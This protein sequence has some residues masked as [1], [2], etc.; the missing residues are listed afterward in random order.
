MEFK[1]NRLVESLANL[2][3][4]SMPMLLRGIINLV[5]QENGGWVIVDYK[6]DQLP[7]IELN[8]AAVHSPRPLSTP[9]VMENLFEDDAHAPL[10]ACAA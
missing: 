8:A 10:N 6:S 4:G 2:A 7:L 9:D 3:S 1:R 5:F